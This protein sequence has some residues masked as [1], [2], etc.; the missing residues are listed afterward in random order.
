MDYQLTDNLTKFNEVQDPKLV[1]SESNVGADI[2]IASDNLLF[3]NDIRREMP[4]A[5]DSY[6]GF[7]VFFKSSGNSFLPYDIFATV[8]YFTSRYEEYSSNDLDKHQRFKAENS[9]AFKHKTLDKPFLNYLIDDFAQKLKQRFSQIEL[10]KRKFNFLS[11]ID[12]DNAFAYANKG[13]RRNFGGAVKD[14]SALKFKNVVTRIK[15]NLN[16]DCDPY[17]TFSIINSY[18][19][20]TVTDLQ[21]FVLIGDYS[22]YDKNPHYTNKNFRALLKKLS[23]RCKVGLHP[24]YETYNDLNKI[25]IEKKRLEDITGKPVTSARCHFLRIKF[26]ETY[27]AF[28]ENG[29]TDDYTMIYASKCGFRT[30]LCVPFKWFDLKRNEPTNLTIHPSTVMEG[31]LRDYN[32]LPV[33][34]AGQQINNLLNEVKQF[35]GEFVSIYH[36]DSFV[37]EQKDWVRLYKDMLSNSK[38]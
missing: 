14:L 11:T 5:S 20:E 13:I 6:L 37:P 36:N 26:P 2:F 27:R 8:F 29:I 24:S 23:T 22:T 3:E 25:A 28:I 31:V 17:N 7:P 10:K 30:G 33:K 15:S 18:G 34:E 19:D 35:G 1:Y 4:K 16:Q 32:K 9:L 12:I 38:L 21:Y